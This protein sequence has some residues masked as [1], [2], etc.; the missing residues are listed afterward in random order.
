[1]K[2][3]K[4]ND[5]IEFKT[6]TTC[7]LRNEPIEGCRNHWQNVVRLKDHESGL[8]EFDVY[9]CLRCQLGFTDPYPTEETTGLLYD[10]KQSSDFDIVKG[11]IID[12]IKDFL[13]RRQI[14]RMAQR[15]RDIQAVLDYATGNGRF[16]M[17]SAKA[18][19]N[20]IIDAVDYQ[21]SAPQLLQLDG[22]QVN[23]FGLK[24]FAERNQ[25]YDLIILRHV[26][27]H[28]HHPVELLKFLG[29]RLAPDG[30][31]YIEVPNLDSGCAKVFGK[32]W[33]GY[34]V[35][36][37]IFHYT[38][39]SLTEIITAAGLK[40]DIGR[41][42]MP[43][44]GNTI[45]ILTGADKSSVFVQCLGILLFPIQMLI[46]FVHRSSTCINARC[47]HSKEV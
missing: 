13:G 45:S 30:I 36:R 37:H 42:E 24:E 35:P 18:F 1:M 40:A 8:G 27:E 5:M 46:E 39:C 44:M 14:V 3:Q 16:A 4:M 22:V 34:Y 21:D 9:F 43:L 20:A 2:K 11:S 23:Y 6:R 38:I 19:P 47:S 7:E 29:D 31:L 25:K 15:G 17:L 41:N 26:L 10:T 12:D 33:K 32:N 28:A